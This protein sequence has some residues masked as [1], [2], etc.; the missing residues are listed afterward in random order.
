MKDATVKCWGMNFGAPPGDPNGF[1][2]AGAPV[3]ID[4][5]GVV[6]IAAGGW[7]CGVLS[8]GS[9]RCWGSGDWV[10]PDLIASMGP[11]IVAPTPTG[12]P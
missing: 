4:E 5:A 11:I 7:A 3:A 10:V 8:D 2:G 1:E 9:I 12:T 6:A